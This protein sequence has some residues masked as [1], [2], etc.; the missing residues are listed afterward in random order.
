MERFI[1]T[2]TKTNEALG[3]SMSQLNSKFE[4]MSTHQKMMETQSAQIT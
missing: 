4:R 1:H 3:E 2:Q